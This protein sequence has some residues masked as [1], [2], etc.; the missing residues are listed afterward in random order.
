MSCLVSPLELMQFKSI[1]TFFTKKK[2]EEKQMIFITHTKF[3]GMRKKVQSE[4]YL[5]LY[6]II[7]LHIV[8]KQNIM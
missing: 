8:N 1:L 2:R 3:V 5:C 6:L 7:I 4:Q